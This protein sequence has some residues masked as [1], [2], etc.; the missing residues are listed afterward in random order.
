MFTG[1]WKLRNPWPV[2][3][4]NVMDT[5]VPVPLYS[6]AMCRAPASTSR[7]WTWPMERVTVTVVV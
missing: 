7:A 6:A 5:G 4:E 3:T 2:S 1:R